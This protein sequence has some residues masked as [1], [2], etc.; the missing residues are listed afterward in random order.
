MKKT[1]LFTIQIIAFFAI[2]GLA[3]ANELSVHKTL[4]ESGVTGGL[5]VHVGDGGGEVL[6]D[7]HANESYLVQGLCPDRE[8]VG[9]GG[10]CSDFRQAI[11]RF[12]CICF[13]KA[14]GK[15]LT[16]LS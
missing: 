3:G 12:S 11:R 5:V 14:G 2:G 9:D 13:P 1:A 4:K 8:S 7:L 6:S 10:A 16:P 15:V